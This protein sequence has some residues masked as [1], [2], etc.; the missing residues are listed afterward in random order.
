MSAAVS[1]R[2]RRVRVLLVDDDPSFR[3]LL[4]ERLSRDGRF[5]VVA[6][7]SDGRRAVELICE[8]R[9]D[10][11]VID[12][13]MPVMDGFEV[14]RRVRDRAPDVKAVVLSGSDASEALQEALDSGA[15]SYLEK[16]T[17]LDRILNVL[18]PL[19]PPEFEDIPDDGDA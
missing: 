8:H 9:P 1:R 2:V 6:E 3:E 16:G 14:L 11:A 12:L 10:V 15:Y 18:A 7:A 19:A 5:V 17:A 4:S 13:T